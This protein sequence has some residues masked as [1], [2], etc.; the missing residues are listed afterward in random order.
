MTGIRI[1]HRAAG[2]K[3]LGDLIVQID[4]VRHDYEGP[5]ARYFAQDL[6]RKENHCKALARSLRLPENSTAPVPC[7]P[8]NQCRPDRIVHPKVLVI[9][10]NGLHQTALV[11]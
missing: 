9:L 7:R 1:A 6:L 11:L 10:S 8:C 2:G 5:V 3:G 4:T